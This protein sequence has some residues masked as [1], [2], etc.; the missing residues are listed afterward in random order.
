MNL[1]LKGVS[2]LEIV[3]VIGIFA[4]V[5]AGVTSLSLK[6]IEIQRDEETLTKHNDIYNTLQ[7]DLRRDLNAAVAVWVG[8]IGLNPVSTYISNPPPTNQNNYVCIT[9]C[10]DVIT[11]PAGDVL[12][13]MVQ[14]G[15]TP[16]SPPTISFTFVR[17]KFFTPADTGI[18]SLGR[19]EG[20]PISYNLDPD[21][22]WPKKLY[23]PFTNPVPG[24][25]PDDTT[26]ANIEGNPDYKLYNDPY[27]N[28]DNAISADGNGAFE[29]VYGRGFAPQLSTSSTWYPSPATNCTFYIDHIN[30][31]AVTITA[32]G[33]QDRYDKV[34]GKAQLNA[35]TLS[36]EVNP[37]LK[38]F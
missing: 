8:D 10:T 37:S 25:M 35:P 5:S 4:V 15:Y 31:R 13:I 14:S 23:A 18:P 29:A 7:D 3:I 2:L 16:G 6:M 20:Q 22:I 12:D 28:E 9:A 21:E 19:F 27:A 24:A 17:Y 30:V 33:Y 11:P 36:F 38:F 34:F 26:F 32:Q 1:R